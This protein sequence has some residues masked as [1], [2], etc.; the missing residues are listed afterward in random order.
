[1]EIVNAIE[2]VD[3]IGLSFIND[4]KVFKTL[5]DQLEIDFDI[6]F[7]RT[8]NVEYRNISQD[9]A[10]KGGWEICINSPFS[11]EAAFIPAKPLYVAMKHAIEHLNYIVRTNT[12]INGDKFAMTRRG[13]FYAQRYLNE[14]GAIDK[15]NHEQSTDGY[16]LTA[17]A[18]QIY[19]SENKS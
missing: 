17:L 12:P 5:I 10:M 18:N 4:Y 1:M 8:L 3:P 19:S 14:K 7:K 16:T 6:S 2:Y 15:I 11:D 13:H 9:E